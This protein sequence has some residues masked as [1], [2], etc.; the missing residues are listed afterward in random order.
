MW[1]ITPSWTVFCLVSFFQEVLRG[2]PILNT[3]L[4]Y[5]HI[6]F[7]ARSSQNEPPIC[8]AIRVF[9][10]FPAGLTTCSRALLAALLARP[11]AAPAR[12]HVVIAMPGPVLP[13]LAVRTKARA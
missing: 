13:P 6:S 9:L 12:R 4:Y 8:A 3:V 2:L 10:D 7:E 5:T 11:P 1:E